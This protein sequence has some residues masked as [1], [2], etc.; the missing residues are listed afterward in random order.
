MDTNDYVRLLG[1]ARKAATLTRNDVHELKKIHSAGLPPY[2]AELKALMRRA[3]SDDDAALLKAAVEGP[4][5][6]NAN[7]RYRLNEAM[8]KRGKRIPG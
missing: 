2:A 1:R 6:L 4:G 7:E 8:N 3:D 5:S